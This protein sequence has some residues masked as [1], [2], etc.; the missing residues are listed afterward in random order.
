MKTFTPRIAVVSPF[1]DKRH[2][3]E[4]HIAEWLPR[5]ANHYDIHLYSQRVEDIDLSKIH[6]HCIPSIPG[7]HIFKYIWWFAANHLWRWRDSELQQL[8]PDIV[9]SPGINC[10]D[11]TAMS[12][13][14]VFADVYEKRRW[15]LTFYSTRFWL[16]PRIVHRW[17]YYRLVMALEKRVYSNSEKSLI[18]IS[19]KTAADIRRFY[20]RQDEFPILY[21]GIDRETFNPRARATYRE[22]MRTQLGFSDSTF[23]LLLVGNDWY[24]KGLLTLIGSLRLLKNLPVCLLVIGNDDISPFQDLMR[25]YD[26][27]NKIQFLRPRPDIAAYYGV[28]DVYVSPSLGDALAQPPGEAMACG[29][30]VIV[31]AMDGASELITNGVDGLIL[32]NPTDESTLAS[33]IELLYRNSDLRRQMGQNAVEAICNRTWDRYASVLSGVFK[34]MIEAQDTCKSMGIPETQ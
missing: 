10:F 12:V 22:P 34:T 2:G 11:A 23:V 20:G 16:W 1:V 15:K 19:R 32:D 17:L 5:L 7:P 28:A 3:T 29:L 30:P 14:V 21:S 8:R 18:S 26:I 13:H 6:W 33:L 25:T 31:S 4:R 27:E 24:N 9:F